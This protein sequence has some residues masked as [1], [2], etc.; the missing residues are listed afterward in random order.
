MDGESGEKVVGKSGS[1]EDI[2]Y[3]SA[4]AFLSDFPTS[5]LTDYMSFQLTNKWTIHFTHIINLPLA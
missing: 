4:R 5:G 1:P 2:H 3:C